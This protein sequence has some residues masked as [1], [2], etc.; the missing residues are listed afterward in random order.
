MSQLNPE[1]RARAGEKPK[2]ILGTSGW[3]YKD[4]IGPFYPP[5]TERSHMLD[6]YVHQFPAVEVNSTYYRIPHPRTFEAIQRKAPP[7]F[8]FV[9]KTH[10]DVTHLQSRD[11]QLYRDFANSIRPLRDA[12]KLTGIL[13]QFPYAF[14]RTPEGEDFLRRLRDLIGGDEPVFVEFRHRSWVDEDVFQELDEQGLG[15]VSV[16]EPDLAGLVP[17]IARRTGSIAYVRFHGRNREKWW[18]AESSTRGAPDRGKGRG[19]EAAEPATAQAGKRIK[20]GARAGSTLGGPGGDLGGDF[21]PL[22]SGT[23]DHPP[24]A[25][26]S[27]R[28]SSTRYDYSYSESE[29]KEWVEK[30]REMT[31]KAKKTFVFF[32]NCHVGQAATS[33]KLMR[34]LLEGEGML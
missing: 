1:E 31:E 16:D 26:E 5:G 12:G 15:Y 22:F 14:R 21:G 3:S 11:P 17:P 13:A 19:K 8:E 32:N 34:K 18:G 6:Y 24:E 7:G 30:I 2:I 29:L 4:W 25:P 23:P 10:H 9:V 20:A 28:T 33:A 27:P